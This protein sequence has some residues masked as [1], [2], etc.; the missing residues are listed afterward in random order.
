MILKSKNKKKKKM[1]FYVYPDSQGLLQSTKK[2]ALQTVKN[3]LCALYR[4]SET[5]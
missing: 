5:L 2:R 4:D 3:V 1:K